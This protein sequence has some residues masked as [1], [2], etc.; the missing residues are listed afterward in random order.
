MSLRVTYRFRVA[1]HVPLDNYIYFTD[2]TKACNVNEN[3]LTRLLR[4]TM[5]FTY[6]T[7][8]R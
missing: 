3:L 5:V 2:L 8:Q 7:S 4:H 6:S 1:Q